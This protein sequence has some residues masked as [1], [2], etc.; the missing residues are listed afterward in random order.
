MLLISKKKKIKFFF[1]ILF[2]PIKK[3]DILKKHSYICPIYKTARRCGTLS[4]TGHSTNFIVAVSLPCDKNTDPS[5]W[6]VRGV[7]LLC[8]LNY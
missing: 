1:Q 7:A 4:T 8:Q 3:T 2:Q 6:I 5:H